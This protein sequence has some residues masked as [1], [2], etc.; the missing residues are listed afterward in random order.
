[1]VE[2]AYINLEN[3]NYDKDG[4]DDYSDNDCG[5]DDDDDDTVISCLCNA[6]LK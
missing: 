2:S 5:D 4:D 6:M 1:M 3:A